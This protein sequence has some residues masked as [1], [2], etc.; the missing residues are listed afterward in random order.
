MRARDVSLGTL[1]YAAGSDSAL[2]GAQAQHMALLAA[3]SAQRRV[4]ALRDGRFRC[5]IARRF[6]PR[7]SEL[8]ISDFCTACSVHG[9]HLRL[10][11]EIPN[12]SQALG[13][14]SNVRVRDPRRQDREQADFHMGI[15]PACRDIDREAKPLMRGGDSC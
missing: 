14:V 15:T 9:Y 10:T 7:V 4:Q 11:G 13:Q 6:C 8:P 3:Q 1:G 2:G 5:A 12:L